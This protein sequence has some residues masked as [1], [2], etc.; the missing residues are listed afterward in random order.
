MSI[1]LDIF[2]F[3]ANDAVE[4]NISVNKEIEEISSP[5]PL[6]PHISLTGLE[7]LVF[8][9]ETTGLR[10]T[11]TVVQLGY[12]L[13]DLAGNLIESYNK[14]LLTRPFEYMDPRAVSVHG[15]G[16][17]DIQNMGVPRK[18]ELLFFHALFQHAQEVGCKIVAHNASFDVRILN[19]TASTEGLAIRFDEKAVFCTM[20]ASKSRCGL[21]QRDDRLKNPKNVELY[22]SLFGRL[23]DADCRMHDAGT[24]ARITAECFVQ[25]QILGW[26]T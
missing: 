1:D 18:A 2:A 14:V 24:D 25:G 16:Q 11:S 20:K 15:S 12:V 17:D 9:T 13:V 19:Q 23:P 7:I 10:D 4:P 3:K 22:Q 8:D 5:Q 26:W 6:Q 21:R